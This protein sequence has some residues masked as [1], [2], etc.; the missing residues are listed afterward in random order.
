MEDNRIIKEVN[1]KDGITDDVFT[2]SQMSRLKETGDLPQEV[3]VP[4]KKIDKD[5]YDGK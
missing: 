4:Q 5:N 3:S 2:S 1:E